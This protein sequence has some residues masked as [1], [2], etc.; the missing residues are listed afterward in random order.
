[1]WEE[2]TRPDD[3]LE[4]PDPLTIDPGQRIDGEWTV[5]KVLGTGS[6]ARALL[7][8]RLREPEGSSDPEEHRVYKIALDE[9]KAA[10]LIDEAAVLR[11]VERDPR[12]V[13]LLDGPFTL[14]RQTVIA[15]EQAGQGSLGQRLRTEGPC[16]IHELERFG[17]D[18]FV[19]LDHLAGEKV[20][21]RDLKPDNLGVRR[22]RDRSQQLVLF[23]F[24]LSRTPERD[25]EV[26]TR[27]Y[28]DP[29]LGE[30][31]VAVLGG[32][33]ASHPARSTPSA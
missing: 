14:G 13:K 23:D 10:R 31:R 32:R 29:F 12:I 4:E 2:L 33:V 11:R 30:A 15:L 27:A 1:V 16:T 7:V 5:T 21:H 9:D 18:L 19:A 28:L 24:S 8:T 22:R 6:T 20:L 17:D 25:I 3:D 26:G